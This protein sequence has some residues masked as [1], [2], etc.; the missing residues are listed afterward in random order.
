MEKCKIAFVGAG[1]IGAGLAVNA[2]LTGHPT[3]VYGRNPEKVEKAVKRVMDAMLAAEAVTAEAARA[4]LARASYTSDVAEAV[5]NAKL[6]QESVAE[7]L[8]LKQEMYRKIQEVCGPDTI[9]ASA[10]SAIMPTKLQEGALYPQSILVGHPY[11]PSYL[12]P[13]IEVCG[14]EQTSQESIDKAMTIY[15]DMGKVP[16]HCKKEVNGFIVNRLS[17]AAMDVA[18]QVV[19]DG[20]CTVEDMDKAIMYGPGMRMAVTGQILTMSLGI[21]GGLREASAKYGKPPSQE[22]LVL[23][24]GVDEEI[25]HRSEEQ[26][27]TVESIM[28]FRD[29]VFT[30]ILKQQGLL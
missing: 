2:M 5:A 27:N 16:V 10:T 11:N 12:L 17:W 30:A 15:R 4:A 24:D 9:I 28:Q 13:V 23:A 26:G 6:V 18:K 20:V 25:A 8:E 22:D 29:K 19:M 1:I 14:G 7:R 21:D 3:A